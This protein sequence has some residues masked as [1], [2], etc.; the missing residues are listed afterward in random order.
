MNNQDNIDRGL[1]MV[2]LQ[3]M[4][5]PAI[6]MHFLDFEKLCKEV[7]VKPIAKDAEWR[8]IPIQIA[9]QSE[10]GN[11]YIVDLKNKFEL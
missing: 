11:F 10:Q 2:A 7:G 3:E 4:K 9:K 8:G 1:E 6:V 5:N